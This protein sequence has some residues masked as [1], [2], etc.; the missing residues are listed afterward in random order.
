M[1]K[2]CV[3]CGRSDFPSDKARRQ[4]EYRM[5][6][7]SE[8]MPTNDKIDQIFES[9]GTPKYS[10]M[11]QEMSGRESQKPKS[12]PRETP[13]TKSNLRQFWREEMERK[14]EEYK[15][16]KFENV[17]D[18]ASEYRTILLSEGM[19]EKLTWRFYEH[20]KKR[21]FAL[22]QSQF[23][24]PQPQPQPQPREI[25]I[26][27]RAELEA[28]KVNAQRGFSQGFICTICGS[29][30]ATYEEA[31]R[32]DKSHSVQN[33]TETPRQ[34][35]VKIQV[36][37]RPQ[38]QALP[39][40]DAVIKGIKS[41]LGKIMSP[42]KTKSEA[43]IE[44]Q[45]TAQVQE[46]ESYSPITYMNT[47]RWS[48]PEPIESQECKICGRVDYISNFKAGLHGRGVCN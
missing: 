35:E 39:Q 29:W 6:K 24:A 15:E 40:S 44:E 10:K 1:S 30:Y 42:P 28:Q 20:I 36:Q 23:V 2:P 22:N 14:I 18:C 31:D 45:E 21:L 13:K 8:S 4:H 41:L 16:G 34:Q 48:P 5:R 33:E 46:T 17:E 27:E 38:P 32:C 37:P 19:E 7:K 25:S 11:F 47:V 26:T 3:C 12:I 9:F 43:K